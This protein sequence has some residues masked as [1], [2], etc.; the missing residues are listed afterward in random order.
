MRG[1]IFDPAART[2]ARLRALESRAK[3]RAEAEAVT[4]GVAETVGLSEARGAAFE[5]PASPGRPYRRQAGLDWLARK[6]KITAAQKSAGERYGA[7]YRRAAREGAIR[8]TLD[9]RPGGGGPAGPGA[10]EE[11]L[12]MAAEGSAQAAARLA[13]M[14]AR[15]WD[16]ADLVSAC[17]LVCGQEL[18]PREAVA[19]EREV[20]RIEALLGVALD[21]LAGGRG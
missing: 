11:V 12:L 19:S 16:Q 1:Q 21:V 7:L 4:G 13:A 10:R 6:G 20:G 14:R 17:D 2:R 18:A 8:S 15:L 3:A 5:G 9:V